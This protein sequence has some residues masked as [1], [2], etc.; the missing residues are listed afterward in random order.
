M[1]ANRSTEYIDAVV[2]PIRKYVSLQLDRTGGLKGVKHRTDR[3][4]YDPNL[5]KNAI[6]NKKDNVKDEIEKT[7]DVHEAKKARVDNDS[8]K[9]K[10]GD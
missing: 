5:Y 8:S 2:K 3:K 9:A 6:G 1:L 10:E 4:G 7:E